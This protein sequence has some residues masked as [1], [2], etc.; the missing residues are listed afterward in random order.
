MTS[1]LLTLIRQKLNFPHWTTSPTV[2]CQTTE[3]LSKYYSLC[4]Q[5]WLNFRWKSYLLWSDIIT[6]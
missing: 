5:C 6:L 2:N 3:Y 1:N 4:S